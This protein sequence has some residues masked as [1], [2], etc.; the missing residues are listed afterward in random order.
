MGMS[1]RLKLW[2]AAGHERYRTVVNN[3]F[4]L[5]SAALVIFYISVESSLDEARKWLTQIRLH[6]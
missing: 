3:Y 4:Y 2:D 6:S 5:A 1:Y